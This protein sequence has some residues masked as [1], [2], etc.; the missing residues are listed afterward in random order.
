MKLFYFYNIN[1]E[2]TNNTGCLTS[3][4]K[5]SQLRDL[6]KTWTYPDGSINP[7]NWNYFTTIGA[8]YGGKYTLPIVQP[9]VQTPMVYL[10]EGYCNCC[11]TTPFK[12]LN[13]VWTHQL[14]YSS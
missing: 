11:K 14:P 5:N 12:N 10:K 2:Q 1:M 3:N 13:D 8:N 6:Q 9:D 7:S 4:C